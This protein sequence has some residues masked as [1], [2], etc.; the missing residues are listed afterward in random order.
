[1]LGLSGKGVPVYM[2]GFGGMVLLALEGIQV[3]KERCNKFTYVYDI[4]IGRPCYVQVTAYPYSCA[5][6]HA[7]KAVSH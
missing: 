1:V 7:V 6:P 4:F 5:A 3:G 2:I